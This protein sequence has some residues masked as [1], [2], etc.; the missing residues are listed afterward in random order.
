MP[1]DSVI[2]RPPEQ[3]TFSYVFIHYKCFLGRLP[4]HQVSGDT[5]ALRPP[6]PGRK[7]NMNQVP[8]NSGNSK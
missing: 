7:R 4:E 1:V 6:K 2:H 3:C 8:Q 5:G